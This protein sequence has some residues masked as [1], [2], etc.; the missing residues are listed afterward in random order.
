M[1]YTLFKEPPIWMRAPGEFVGVSFCSA[2]V[3]FGAGVAPKPM[4]RFF[5]IEFGVEFG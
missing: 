2:A 5:A 3:N 4:A 1:A